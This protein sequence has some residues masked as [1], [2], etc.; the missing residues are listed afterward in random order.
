MCYNFNTT[1][2][3]RSDQTACMHMLF[4]AFIAC[5]QTGIKGVN[6]FNAQ[7]SQL[8]IQFILLINVKMPT[9]VGIRT[10][11]SKINITAESLKSKIKQIFFNILSFMSN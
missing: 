10:F 11:M 7:L 3:K 1:N 9:I 2:Y 6:C 8:C 5:I 4:R